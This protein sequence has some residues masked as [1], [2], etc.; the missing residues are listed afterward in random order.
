MDE[1]AA[2]ILL[3]EDNSGDAMLFTEMLVDCPRCYNVTRASRISESL[4]LI[5]ENH[6]DLI[7]MDLN[8]PDERGVNALARIK[9]KTK[10][11]IIILTGSFDKEMKYK[12][13]G[14]GVKY[15]FMKG[16]VEAFELCDAIS[17][18]L[19]QSEGQT[20]PPQG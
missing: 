9:D 15:Y 20:V 1:T 19:D 5:D 2:D 14:D 7:V 13:L 16:K 11:P 3:I 17:Q 6:F 4:A 10:L 18:C 8:L 12:S